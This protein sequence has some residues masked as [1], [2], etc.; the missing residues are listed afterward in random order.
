MSDTERGD[1]L[2]RVSA[3]ERPFENLVA[4]QARWVGNR[5]DTRFPLNLLLE[6]EEHRLSVRVRPGLLQRIGQGLPARPPSP[7][8]SAAAYPT[9][10]LLRSVPVSGDRHRRRKQVRERDLRR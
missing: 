2:F 6:V 5:L 7:S 4:L 1:G 9:A 10:S 8:K 3:T